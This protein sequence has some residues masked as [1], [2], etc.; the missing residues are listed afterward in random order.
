MAENL[1]AFDQLKETTAWSL[2]QKEKADLNAINQNDIREAKTRIENKTFVVDGRTMTLKYIVE[3]LKI[4]KS[5]D[6]ATLFWKEIPRKSE[7]WA[8]IQVYALA[9]NKSIGPAVIDWKV[10]RWT[11]RWLEITQT[12]MKAE[13]KAKEVTSQW[14]KIW[15]KDLATHVFTTEFNTLTSTKKFKDMWILTSD[16][17][18]NF[19]NTYPTPLD[20]NWNC[21]ISYISQQDGKHKTLSVKIKKDIN[22]K[23]DCL[24]IAKDVKIAAENAESKIYK[25]NKE[26]RIISWIDNY[27]IGQS[28]LSK[29]AKAYLRDNH[30]VNYWTFNTSKQYFNK[31]KLSF[32][33]DWWL[34]FWNLFHMQKSTVDSFYTGW[35][36][37]ATN[38]GKYINGD[39][40]R[41]FIDGLANK[42][43]V[44]SVRKKVNSLKNSKITTGSIVSFNQKV[45]QVETQISTVKSLW[46][47]IPSD[48]QR[49]LDSRKQSMEYV[50]NYK[51]VSEAVDKEL[52]GYEKKATEK[53]S[54][55]T[56]QD[57]KN[58]QAKITN[59]V[60]SLELHTYTCKGKDVYDVYKKMANWEKLY[61]TLLNRAK[62][63]KNRV[64]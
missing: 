35:K 9:H 12:D 19:K 48:I 22:D 28:K 64:C 11:V 1:K 30:I 61:Q 27:D 47:A 25:N 31:D 14:E 36:F 38:F 41:S 20:Q 59:L 44:D 60:R 21:H 15:I 53:L 42:Y 51:T 63:I 52:S 37:N 32:R 13:W 56:M 50:R 46:V 54:N 2:S 45:A 49:D 57:V 10:W 40:F 24:T 4:N 34:T 26:S 29:K 23:V 62:R 17:Y 5:W 3:N 7:L 39:K 16:G 58:F 33:A 55:M 8:A 18:L 43:Y 6:R